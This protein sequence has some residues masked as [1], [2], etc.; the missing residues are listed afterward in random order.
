MARVSGKL[1]AADVEKQKVVQI[2]QH[3]VSGPCWR[4]RTM[5]H[6]CNGILAAMTNRA[7]TGPRQQP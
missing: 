5:V 3:Q 6:R 1:T 4:D 7:R 2:L